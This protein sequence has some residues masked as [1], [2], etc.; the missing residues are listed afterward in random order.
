MA[1]LLDEV[2][3]RTR[4]S[5][6][7]SHQGAPASSDSATAAGT[8]ASQASPPMDA[9]N[10]VRTK[11]SRSFSNLAMALRRDTAKTAASSAQ[12]PSTAAEADGTAA[13]A[14]DRSQGSGLLRRSRSLGRIV[15]RA[16]SFSS[17]SNHEKKSCASE[18][19]AAAAAPVPRHV[20]K[21]RSR[22]EQLQAQRDTHSGSEPGLVLPSSHSPIGS[23][24]EVHRPAAPQ[25]SAFSQY[26][27]GRYLSSAPYQG[28]VRSNPKTV[29]IA[30]EKPKRRR[31]VTVPQAT[32]MVPGN[33][34]THT[35]KIDQ[36]A[37]Q[38]LGSV[39][40]EGAHAVNVH[41]LPNG[42]KLP[43]DAAVVYVHDNPAAIAFR[44]GIPKHTKLRILSLENTGATSLPAHLIRARDTLEVLNVS[45]SHGIQNFYPLRDLDGKK[46]T[47]F[48]SESQRAAIEEVTKAPDYQGP[49]VR[50]EP[51]R[52]PAPKVTTWKLASTRARLNPR[53][54][55][56]E[57][58]E[59]LQREGNDQAKK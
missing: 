24:S 26:V 40:P 16:K 29:L 43:A 46:C 19:E 59:T 5:T 7:W 8:S 17:K 1:K 13:A 36:L 30:S 39:Q 25:L 20:S 53:F 22:L 55:L 37:E 21:E 52:S 50:F 14:A 58:H 47:V 56:S 12:P 41:P 48:A 27:Q 9:D 3:V 45:S 10:P 15:Q 38:M 6:G 35:V 11:R 33:K 57:M 49:P 23:R 31:S 34:E 32:S 42:S 18:E 28:F 4:R 44:G 51:D 2:S 54:T